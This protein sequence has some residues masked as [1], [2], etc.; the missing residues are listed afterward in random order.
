MLEN[1]RLETVKIKM[2][3]RKNNHHHAKTLVR[4]LGDVLW[5]GGLGRLG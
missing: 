2:S 1:F 4:E 3:D 5:I